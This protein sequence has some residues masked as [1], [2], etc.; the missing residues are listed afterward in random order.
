VRELAPAF[1]FWAAISTFASPKQPKSRP[2]KSI[3]YELLFS[4]FF[5]NSFWLNHFHTPRKMMGGGG[6]HRLWYGPGGCLT[7]RIW[8]SNSPKLKVKLRSSNLRSWLL[9]RDDLEDFGGVAL[10]FDEG[11][12]FFDFAGFADD[13][14]T[15]D[16]AHEGAAHELLFLPG[17]EFLNGFVSGVAEQR[18]IEPVL[19][20]EGNKG[21][22]GIGAHAENGDV[23]LVE[24]LLCVTKLGRFDGSTGS[25]GF[26]K[27]KQKHA[28]A[29]E[30]FERDF[31]TFVAFEAK[32]GGFRAYF[33]HLDVP[34]S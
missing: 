27:E 25:A 26:G 30:V 3:T 13:E 21:F 17:A 19:F 24:L 14:R 15:A 33:E 34:L 4:A 8:R 32:G 29:G 18:E 1:L 12:E 16:D 31:M 7:D 9:F 28:L 10:G 23:E 11:P 5:E 2:L 6:L 22:D 20:L